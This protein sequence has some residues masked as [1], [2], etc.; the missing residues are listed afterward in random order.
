MPAAGEGRDHARLAVG[1][2]DALNHGP[3]AGVATAEFVDDFS[4]G[5]RV[6]R[7]FP[8]MPGALGGVAVTVLHGG[9]RSALSLERQHEGGTRLAHH[10]S[11]TPCFEACWQAPG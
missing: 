9:D 4:L 5:R 10:V 8:E 6:V 3:V 2:D 7:A 11:G 1:P